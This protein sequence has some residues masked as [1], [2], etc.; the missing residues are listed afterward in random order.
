MV[1]LCGEGSNS[2]STEKNRKKIDLSDFSIYF[3]FQAIPNLPF[4]SFW[5]SLKSFIIIA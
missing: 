1:Q 4:S 5:T 3:K 2:I